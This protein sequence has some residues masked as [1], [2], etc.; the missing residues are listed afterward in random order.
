[1][2]KHYF[3]NLKEIWFNDSVTIC[4]NIVIISYK[5]VINFFKIYNAYNTEYNMRNSFWETSE[6]S[7]EYS[8]RI[9]QK[10]PFKE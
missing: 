9:L 6:M 2:I 5:K 3:L 7:A 10:I 8:F 1:M 4:I